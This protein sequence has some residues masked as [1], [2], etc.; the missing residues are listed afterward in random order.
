ME[1]E[2]LEEARDQCA[3]TIPGLS[4]LVTGLRGLNEVL[5]DLEDAIRAC[6]RDQEFGER[7]I[8]LAR[9][10]YRTNDRRAALKRRIDELLDARLR[11]EKSYTE[12]D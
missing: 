6:E 11:Q 8:A 7:F 3:A 4:E 10:I 9:S 12:Y 2:A 1:L 5:W